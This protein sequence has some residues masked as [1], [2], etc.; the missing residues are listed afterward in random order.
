MF[1]QSVHPEDSVDLE[2]Y[3]WVQLASCQHVAARLVFFSEAS[4]KSG[5]EL[6][7]ANLPLQ[8]NKT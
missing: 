6:L 3:Y 4:A 7:G 8:I 5:A 2:P 1:K